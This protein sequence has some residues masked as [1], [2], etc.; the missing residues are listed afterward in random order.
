MNLDVIGKKFS[1]GDMVSSSD[2]KRG[3]VLGYYSTAMVEVR[4]WDGLRHV[5][6]VC[7]DERG[8][9]KCQGASNG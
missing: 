9:T 1:T 8:L 5:G 6:D 2:F 3:C 4:I 7:V